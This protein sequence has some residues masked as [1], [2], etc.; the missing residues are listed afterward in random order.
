MEREFCLLTHLTVLY[1]DM[2]NAY[3]AWGKEPTAE[4]YCTYL[5][6]K[7]KLHKS[8]GQGLEERINGSR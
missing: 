4:G 5:E 6:Y 2:K 3:D 1:I 8:L 7:E